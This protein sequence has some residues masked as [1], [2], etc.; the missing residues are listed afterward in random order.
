MDPAVKKIR[1]RPWNDPADPDDGLRILVTS[2]RRCPPRAE[3]LLEPH[4]YF[5]PNQTQS[6]ITRRGERGRPS[7]P[8][9]IK[10][11]PSTK[12]CGGPSPAD[13][14]QAGRAEA[15]G[16]RESP[17]PLPTQFRLNRSQ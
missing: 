5:E 11:L 1:T 13:R 10:V 14:P 4:R 2:Y 3:A 6:P 8:N 16:R 15:R 9:Q 12:R 7:P 17:Q